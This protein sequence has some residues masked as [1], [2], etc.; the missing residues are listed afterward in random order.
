MESNKT[1][2]L[3]RAKPSSHKKNKR[4]KIQN[5]IAI[6]KKK[7]SILARRKTIKNL[8]RKKIKKE[9][10]NNRKNPNK[11]IKIVTRRS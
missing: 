9:T 5:K 4:N 7:R 2:L 1:R 10:N 3:L 6:P 11:S 8:I